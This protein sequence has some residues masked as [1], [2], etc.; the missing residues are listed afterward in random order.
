M[1]VLMQSS[2]FNKIFSQRKKEAWER[3]I[4]SVRRLANSGDRKLIRKI[5]RHM[6]QTNI[7]VDE[8]RVLNQISHDIFVASLFC[9][10]PK[11]NVICRSLQIEYLHG[12][13]FTVDKKETKINSKKYPIDYAEF[14]I[15]NC[16]G[17]L[18][19]ADK[20]DVNRRRV[21]DESFIFKEY[22]ENE[23]KRTAYLIIS[24]SYFSG[25]KLSK[26]QGK[27]IKVVNLN[28]VAL[29]ENSHWEDSITDNDLPSMFERQKTKRTSDM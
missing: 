21:Y 20:L 22:V 7:E 3:N 14:I 16:I 15:N 5:R 4:I 28:N 23:Y 19:H 27:Y 25:S 29:S 13:S 1:I 24:G 8:S 17:K 26:L 2:E 9:N 10:K 12:I 18:V 6:R 11:P